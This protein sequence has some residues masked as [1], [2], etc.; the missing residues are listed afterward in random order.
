MPAELTLVITVSIARQ[1]ACCTKVINDNENALMHEICTLTRLAIRKP[2]SS[3]PE[4]KKH[5]SQMSN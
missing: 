1:V 2:R 3:R 5:D 4:A